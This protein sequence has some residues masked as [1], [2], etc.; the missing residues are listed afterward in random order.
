M[1]SGGLDP[2]LLPTPPARARG[3]ILALSRRLHLGFSVASGYA[4]FSR[5]ESRAQLLLVAGSASLFPESSPEVGISALSSTPV[6]AW[7]AP[8]RAASHGC[9][10]PG[11]PA[12]APASAAVA[13]A[14]PC[15]LCLRWIPGRQP[16]QPR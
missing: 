3:T 4:F 2:R 5:A 14:A 11:T 15:D 1:L 13:T 8:E 10:R 16:C 6:R 12:S 7:V 9:V